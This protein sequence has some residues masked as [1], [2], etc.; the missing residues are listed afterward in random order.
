MDLDQQFFDPAEFDR[1]EALFF[2]VHLIVKETVEGAEHL[3]AVAAGP[4][5]E[6]AVT[7]A[8]AQAA[9][10]PRVSAPDMSIRVYH[11]AR[12]AEA[13]LAT[14]V[15]GFRSRGYGVAFGVNGSDPGEL[16]RLLAHAPDAIRL[17]APHLRAAAG[18]P[19]PS[20]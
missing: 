15:A 3:A 16:G 13:R 1:A 10:A 17:G 14:A 19:A 7:A 9:D 4:P 5:V 2:E 12:V 20:A 8:A 11:D 18:E 6:G